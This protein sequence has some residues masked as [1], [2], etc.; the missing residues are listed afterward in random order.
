MILSSPTT[1]LKSL[2]TKFSHAVC[3][4]S[5]PRNDN[6]LSR[7]P[8]A[9]WSLLLSQRQQFLNNHL[10]RVPVT[11]NQQGTH[12]MRESLDTKGYQVSADL[13][14]VETYWENDQLVVNA[15]FRPGIVTSFS[16]PN[17]NDF[18]MGSMAEKPILVDKERDKE[19]SL[20]PH[21]TIPVSET[22]T[23]APV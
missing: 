12:E 23:Q 9:A 13:D 16:P 8:L 18:E 6:K 11:T 5:R 7:F 20:P 22:P 2:S 21:P 10:A 17:F 3:K 4:R 14:A 15:V 19:S 1:V